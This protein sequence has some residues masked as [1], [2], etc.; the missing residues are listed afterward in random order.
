ML[1]V[2]RESSDDEAYSQDSD[3]YEYFTEKSCSVNSDDEG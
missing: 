1:G 3:E 2:D